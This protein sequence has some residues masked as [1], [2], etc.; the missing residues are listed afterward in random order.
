MGRT[1]TTH[2]EEEPPS[3]IELYLQVGQED[4]TVLEKDHLQVPLETLVT[5]FVLRQSGCIAA[6]HETKVGPELKV[7]LTKSNSNNE[8]PPMVSIKFDSCYQMRDELSESSQAFACVLPAVYIPSQ[9]LCI[10][11]LCSVLRFLLKHMSPDKTLLGYQGGCLSAPA[12]VSTWTRFCEVDMPLATLAILLGDGNRLLPEELAQFETHMCQPIRMH[13]I[14]KRMQQQQLN[15]IIHVEDG[16]QVSVDVDGVKVDPITMFARAQHL[17]AE[18]PDCLLSDVV[19]FPYYHLIFAKLGSSS[20]DHLLPNTCQWYNRILAEQDSFGTASS[21]VFQV[22]EYLP[23]D[24]KLELPK[25]TNQSLYKSDPKRRNPAARIYTRQPDIDRVFAAVQESNL[26][27]LS[28]ASTADQDGPLANLDWDNLPELVHPLG[29]HLPPE[30]LDK[31]CQQLENLAIPVL[32]LVQPGNTIVD[33]CSGGGHLAILLAYLRPDC[34]VHLVENKEES[35]KRA[36]KRVQALGLDNCRFFQG[37]MDYFVGKFDVGVSLHA[38]GVATDLVIQ[39]CV[40]N[41]ASFVTCPCCYGSVQENHKVG[42][43]RSK[44]FA[45]A[46]ISFKDYLVIGHTADQTHVT[47]EKDHQGQLAMDIIDT[48]RVTFAT[49]HGYDIR[50]TKLKPVSCTPKNNLIV[51]RYVK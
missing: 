10:T 16:C 3:V 21:S 26:D 24:E 22:V 28:S 29:G 50:L 13:N 42:Y 39:A 41:K 11:G 32:E 30:R 19:L 15:N 36:M 25:V 9:Q 51:A 34:T 33:F 23:K 12:E 38:C 37:N 4:H 31:K 17:Y 44:N 35:L 6:E 8:S 7:I 18:G 1:K 20:L 46:E 14:R 45:S 2:I 40:D 47:N 49:E 43:P 48:D 5:L 27:I